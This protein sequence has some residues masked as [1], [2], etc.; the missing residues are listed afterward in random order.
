[1]TENWEKIRAEME[2]EADEFVKRRKIAN[3]LAGTRSF[4]NPETARGYGTREAVQARVEKLSRFRHEAEHLYVFRDP[5][6]G[7]GVRADTHDE[8]GCKRWKMIG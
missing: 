4:G 5:C 1:M 8:H 6:G 2:A 3:Q 7:C